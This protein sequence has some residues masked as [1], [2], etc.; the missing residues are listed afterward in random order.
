MGTETCNFEFAMDPTSD[1]KRR[2]RLTLDP[3]YKCLMLKIDKD[4]VVGVVD[5]NQKS[6]IV[7][8]RQN[9]DFE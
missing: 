8:K 1:I 4:S 2:I 7:R 6:P 3:T 9:I 5:R